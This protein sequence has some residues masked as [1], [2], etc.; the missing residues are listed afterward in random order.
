MFNQKPPEIANSL[1]TGIFETYLDGMI[2]LR[3]LFGQNCPIH[4]P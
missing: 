2:Y 1:L 4:F 3:I